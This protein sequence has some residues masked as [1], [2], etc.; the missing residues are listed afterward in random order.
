MYET[1]SEIYTYHENNDMHHVP[2]KFLF[3]SELEEVFLDYLEYLCTTDISFREDYIT[4]RAEMQLELSQ[5]T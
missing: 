4:T 3:S 1:L 5:D 2:I